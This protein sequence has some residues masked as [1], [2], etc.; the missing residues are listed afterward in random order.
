MNKNIYCTY[1]YL[2]LFVTMFMSKIL[3]ALSSTI[4]IAQKKII[5]YMQKLLEA[6][7]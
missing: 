3:Y 4:N 6:F 2:K 5:P 7:H 1:F